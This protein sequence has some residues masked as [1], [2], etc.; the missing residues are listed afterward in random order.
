VD[1]TVIIPCYNSAAWV[2][3]TIESVLAQ[4]VRPAEIVVV[5]DGSTDDSRDVLS[6]YEP[7]IRVVDQ[8]NCGLSGARNS[9]VRA[10]TTEWLAF[11]DADDLFETDFVRAV[12]EL[13]ADYPDVRVA[14]T[15][16]SELTDGR[17]SMGSSFRTFVPDLREF[18]AE[19]HGDL[20][21]M[22]D[23]F[24]EVLIRSNGA[25]APSTLVVRRDQFDKAGGFHEPM[26]STEDLDFYV[27]VA[28]G[29]ACGLVDRPLL[30]RRQHPTSL[31][32]NYAVVRPNV[33][34]F[35]HRAREY[36]QSHYPHLLRAVEDKYCGLLASFGR[37][38]RRLGMH[39]AA[40][41]TF[42]QLVRHNPWR[43]RYWYH[44]AAAVGGVPVPSPKRRR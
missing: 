44:L 1:L 42:Y 18:C 22:G 31:G 38:E 13:H 36:Y 33:D 15:D 34:V 25:F 17:I 32:R 28:P 3:E 10:S 37:A 11:L 20:L 43:V 30:R 6:R 23:R 19:A 24:P 35:Y 4:T 2:G 16:H 40:R 7:H 5:N 21:R 26:R 27:R 8:A 14:F 39:R 12:G 29:T 41:A 9:G